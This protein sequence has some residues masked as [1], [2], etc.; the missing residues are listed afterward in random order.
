V[1]AYQVALSDECGTSE[2][3]F[4]LNP[5]FLF[6][7]D[8]LVSTGSLDEV[9]G[10]RSEEK[11]AIPVTLQTLDHFMDSY[12]GNGIDVIKI[13]TESTEHMV[14]KGA[15]KTFETHR[16]IV[17]CEV[18]PNRVETEIQQ[19]I[20]AL[21]YALFRI[22]GHALEEVSDLKHDARSTNDFLFCPAE[23]VSLL[24]SVG[25]VVRQ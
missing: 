23:K 8:Q 17:F 20:A 6:V 3:H 25:T 1:D 16:P 7:K 22:E 24:E 13:D 5:K 9:Q 12:E 4:S 11:I 10:Y 15:R 2:F 21:N 19:E 14:I 18:L